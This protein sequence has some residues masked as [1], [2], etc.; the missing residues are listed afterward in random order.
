MVTGATV[1]VTGGACGAKT[2]VPE[3]VPSPPAI[4]VRPTGRPRLLAGIVVPRVSVTAASIC[5]S[6]PAHNA[7]LP[8]VVTMA[9][10]TL[11][12]CPAFRRMLPLV[13]VSAPCTLMSLPQQATIL[14]FVAVIGALMLTS[15]WAFSV[16]VVAVPEAVQAMASLMMI[17]P[18]PPV[19]PPCVGRAKT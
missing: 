9:W 4:S 2:I 16:S 6:C 14:P 11:T 13:V 12:F 8:S 5:T 17:S 15:R 7:M 3:P 19:A 10:N 18:L 1:T